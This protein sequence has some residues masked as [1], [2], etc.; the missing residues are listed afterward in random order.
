MIQIHRHSLLSAI[1]LSAVIFSAIA[2][3]DGQSQ[4]T[5]RFT[6]QTELVLVPT[7][8]TDKSGAHAAGLTKEDFTIFENGVE[9]K[10]AV[11]EEIITSKEQA[12]L[13]TLAVGEFSNFAQPAQGISEPQRSHRLTIIVFD[14]I[15]TPALKQNAG[16]AALLKFIE[17]AAA[18]EEPTAIYSFG[19]RG[20]QCISDFTTDPNVLASAVRR[21]KQG[22][23]VAEVRGLEATE[24]ESA[25]VDRDSA[26]MSVG[27]ITLFVPPSGSGNRSQVI[28]MQLEKFQQDLQE[29]F[30]SFETHLSAAVTLEAL[31][32]I[33]HAVAGI[34]G[35]KS[36]I[37]VTGGFPFE[38]GRDQKDVAFISGRHSWRDLLPIYQSTWKAL[39]QAQVAMYP[40]DVRGVVDGDKVMPSLKHLT[41]SF[42]TRTDWEY[43]QTINTFTTF[44][45]ATGGKAYYNSN[46]LEKGFSEAVNDSRSYYLLGYYVNRETA[47]KPGWRTLAV[48]SK[49]KDIRVRA[50]SGYQPNAVDGDPKATRDRD[51]SVALASP[52]DFTGIAMKAR[53]RDSPATVDGKKQVTFDLQIVP[54]ITSIQASNATQLSLEIVTA[55][56]TA[57]GKFVAQPTVRGFNAPLE[58]ATTERIREKGLSFTNSLQLA[59]G[60]YTIWLVVRDTLSGQMGTLITPLV[61]ER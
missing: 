44:A 54:N 46:D 56:K 9:Q 12:K 36:L 2:F 40:I 19:H 16:R 37:W 35:R 26:G 60:S 39:N 45:E 20:V 24:H 28:Q 59:P 10:T 31:Q 55:V 17:K 43:H 11:F 1:I 21:V 15:N 38:I 58:E 48:K 41:G 47:A 5:P 14:L 53:W 61:V 29:N 7:I 3:A 51:L 33:A 6:S 18:S 34:P 4:P 13:P 30:T 22:G 50:R 42:A 57:D 25:T 23:K 32:D 27:N 52:I 49:R 8:V